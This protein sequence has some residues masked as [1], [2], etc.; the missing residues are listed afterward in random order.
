MNLHRRSADKKNDHQHGFSLIEL[1]IVLSITPLLL[2][3]TLN[4]FNDYQANSQLNI[5]HQEM[6][7]ALTD[8]RM[9]AVTGINGSRHGVYTDAVAGTFTV[10]EGT[11]Y[12]SRNQMNDI[13]YTWNPGFVT[14]AG[15]AEIH[16]S[17]LRGTTSP[18][19]ITLTNTANNQ[20]TIQI[21]EAGSLQ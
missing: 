15:L 6:R 1:V 7:Q 5:A 12:A 14:Y 18:A 13:V 10:F 21:N 9:K 3:I 16:F 8:A 20:Q 2:L 11:T 4:L 17:K 19:T